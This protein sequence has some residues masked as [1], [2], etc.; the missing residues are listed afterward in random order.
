MGVARLVRG[1]HRI[2]AHVNDFETGGQE[3]W[4]VFRLLDS[5]AQFSAK[6]FARIANPVDPQHPRLSVG[7]TWDLLLF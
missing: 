6:K 1:S 5:G 7:L 4:R 3:T 2:S